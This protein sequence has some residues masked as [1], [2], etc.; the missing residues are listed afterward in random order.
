MCMLRKCMVSASNLCEVDRQRS[1][2]QNLF[3][4]IMYSAGRG[5]S[6]FLVQVNAALSLLNRLA[7]SLRWLDSWALWVFDV[8]F[9]WR[10]PSAD[11]AVALPPAATGGRECE[12][13]K[14]QRDLRRYILTF[15]GG[16]GK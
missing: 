1:S 10:C 3:N 6:G 16:D 5:D 8:R 4:A 9:N 15:T 14:V 2:T 7:G 11:F 13:V 12:L